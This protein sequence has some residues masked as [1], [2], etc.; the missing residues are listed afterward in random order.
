M[1]ETKNKEEV[2]MLLTHLNIEKLALALK[3]GGK[4][5]NGPRVKSALY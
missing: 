3:M 4:R 2:R 5:I 1:V